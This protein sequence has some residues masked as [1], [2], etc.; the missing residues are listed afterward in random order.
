[1][2]KDTRTTL[3]IKNLP[4]KFSKID[5][6]NDFNNNGFSGLYDFFYLIPDLNVN[7]YR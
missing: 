4:N 5:M 6:M 7:S 3:M 1:M 2:M